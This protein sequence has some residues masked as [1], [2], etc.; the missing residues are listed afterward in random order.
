MTPRVIPEVVIPEAVILVVAALPALLISPGLLLVLMI[1]NPVSVLWIVTFS[2][3]LLMFNPG[4]G[5]WT[6]LLTRLPMI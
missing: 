6:T 4:W 5:R 1:L 3:V 2:P